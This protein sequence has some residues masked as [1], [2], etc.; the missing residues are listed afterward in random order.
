MIKVLKRTNKIDST[1][2]VFLDSPMGISATRVYGKYPELYNETLQTEFEND[3]PF[4]F[5]G[6]TITRSHKQSMRIRNNFGRKVVIAGSGM[7]TGGRV[8]GHAAQILPHEK[9]RLLFVGFQGEE[10]L[11][12]AIKE[13]AK[14]VEIEGISVPVNATIS[15]ID[16]LSAH[17]DQPRL[18][19]WVK[20]I[21]GVKKVV[22]IHGED[23]GPR[24]VFAKLLKDQL[25]DV[26]LYLPH[27]DDEVLL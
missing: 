16:N 25:G 26:E 27:M 20:K 6:L 17:A 10:T 22:L 7:M 1:V 12:R 23:G 18:L 14:E 11:G 19:Q 15:T 13:G 2:P 9:N 4:S 5:P 8:V 21:Q 24:E 3:D